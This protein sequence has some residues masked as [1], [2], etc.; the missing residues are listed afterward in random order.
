MHLGEQI[1]KSS[2]GVHVDFC[3]SQMYSRTAAKVGAV[4]PSLFCLELHGNHS[5]Q[6]QYRHSGGYP[7]CL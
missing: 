4:V 2:R 6:T 5:Y 1:Q 3:C 7:P